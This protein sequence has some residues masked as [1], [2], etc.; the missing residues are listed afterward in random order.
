[1]TTKYGSGSGDQTKWIYPDEAGIEKLAIENSTVID[2]ITALGKKPEDFTE[3]QQWWGNM[4]IDGVF[5]Q[6]FEGQIS[7][8]RVISDSH[9]TPRGLRVGDTWK[10]LL[11]LY[12]EPDKGFR[13]DKSLTYYL[14]E[15][16]DE[17][18]YLYTPRMNI[19]LDEQE[20]VKYFE[21]V[22]L[23]AD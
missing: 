18:G 15:S 1:M 5:I 19:E 6:G 17:P 9:A 10:T 16:R 21:F 14:S 12:G 7:K 22:Q 23:F 20:K 11:S 2:V 3:Q 4:E 8:L 13:E